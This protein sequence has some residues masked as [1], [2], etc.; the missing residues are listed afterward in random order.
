MSRRRIATALIALA[1]LAGACGDDEAEPQ[2][3]GPK[4][5]TPAPVEDALTTAAPP[6]PVAPSPAGASTPDDAAI[7]L[8][9]HWVA[10]DAT[11]A[12]ETA[13]QQAVNE[14]FAHPGNPLQ[15]SGCI[16]EGVKHTCFFYYEGGGLN[17][18]VT[19]G[20]AEGYL[21]TKTFF[22]AD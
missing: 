20:P 14:L 22:V 9:D 11:G 18:I 13:T 10:G 4:S 21:V 12:L 15:F 3:K 2:A 5:N 16:R 17:M 1:L 8:H 19:G 7:T 6:S